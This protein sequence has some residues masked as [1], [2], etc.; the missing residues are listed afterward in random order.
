[1]ILQE[2]QDSSVLLNVCKSLRLLF[3]YSVLW[4]WAKVLGNIYLTN[5]FLT[6][7]TSLFYLMLERKGSFE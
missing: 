2:V 1:M 4:G 5:Q 6:L 7:F 3:L